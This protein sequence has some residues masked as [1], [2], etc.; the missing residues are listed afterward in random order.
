[1]KKK[2]KKDHHS[3]TDSSDS[4]EKSNKKKKR[5]KSNKKKKKS[6]KSVSRDRKVKKK[7]Y[8]SWG[9]P[10]DGR[11]PWDRRE[12]DDPSRIPGP[13]FI[14]EDVRVEMLLQIRSF[15][16]EGLL[17]CTDDIHGLLDFYDD[18]KENYSRYW[19]LL[20]R[21]LTFQDIADVVDRF[22]HAMML[23]GEG[24][25]D[26]PAEEQHVSDEE[27]VQHEREEVRSKASHKKKDKKDH[28]KSKEG[29]RSPSKE[30]EESDK[31]EED[32]TGLLDPAI[33]M[34]LGKTKKKGTSSKDVPSGKKD[35][36]SKG[37]ESGKPKPKMK[38]R[39]GGKPGDGDDS[40]DD[41][42]MPGHPKKGKDAG[43]GR[44]K[45]HKKGRRRSPSGGS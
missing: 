1:M 38:S 41:S 30:P 7:G 39:D 24:M 10:D 32:A 5:K 34:T 33:A 45:G 15:W 12:E 43:K 22:D 16:H 31:E 42:D 25:D 11:H 36:T 26:E 4:D 14:P 2:K 9:A 28:K 17:T 8:K 19:R 44:G 23:R 18:H 6:K 21:W 37:H 27:E 13:S 29:R 40:D 20:L 3:S 35:K